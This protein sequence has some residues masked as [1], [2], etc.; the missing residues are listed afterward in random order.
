MPKEVDAYMIPFW[1]L[2]LVSAGNP[3]LRQLTIEAD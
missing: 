2:A 1:N 3:M